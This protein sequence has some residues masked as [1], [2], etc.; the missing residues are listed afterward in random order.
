M[1]VWIHNCWKIED[2]IQTHEYTENLPVQN[3]ISV[4][5][6]LSCYTKTWSQV[7]SST[8]TRLFPLPVLA[9][10][11]QRPAEGQ[12]GFESTNG[13]GG[14][15]R[16]GMKEAW[17]MHN[18]GLCVGSTVTSG[19]TERRGVWCIKTQKQSL[20]WGRKVRRRSVGQRF[21]WD[22]EMNRSEIISMTDAGFSG[23]WKTPDTALK[24]LP[25]GRYHRQ[26]ADLSRWVMKMHNF[27]K[28]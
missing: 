13:V 3:L 28:Y 22:T 7:A 26:P 4:T 25:V 21:L 6:A 24:F 18:R 14:D 8:D 17:E 11:R 1:Y 16:E 10:A 23:N 2:N 9:R 19:Q 5:Q 12:T 20:M 27:S 15:G